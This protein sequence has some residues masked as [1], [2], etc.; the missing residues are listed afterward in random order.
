MSKYDNQEGF[1]QRMGL[2]AQDLADSDTTWELLHDIAVDY[3]ARRNEFDNAAQ[4]FAR[5]MQGFKAVHSVRWRVKDTDH[6]LE[7]IVRKRKDRNRKYRDITVANYRVKVTDLVGLRALHL[8]KDDCVSIDKDIRAAWPQKE[9]PTAYIREGDT[10][11]QQLRDMRL[12]VKNHKDGYRSIHYICQTQPTKAVV[13]AEIQVRTI[14]EEGWSEIDHRIRYPNHSKDEVVKYF[15]RIFN[16]LAGSADEMGTFV[17]R[18]AMERE[19]LNRQRTELL[20]RIEEGVQRIADLEAEHSDAAKAKTTVRKLQA[21]TAE[22]R[23]LL[24]LSESLSPTSL[25]IEPS[26]SAMSMSETAR[27]IARRIAD[28][29]IHRQPTSDRRREG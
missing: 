27:R 2:T 10:A 9:K 11:R 13:L 6:L 23:E 29:A 14:F 19:G 16:S 15:L 17:Q 21:E 4:V 3:E 12:T 25:L 22:L 26:G 20:Q 7:K 24:A 5:A 1:L 8:F 28:N 18:L